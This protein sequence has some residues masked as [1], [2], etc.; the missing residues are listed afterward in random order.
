MNDKEERGK[1]REHEEKGVRDGEK[2]GARNRPKNGEKDAKHENNKKGEEKI[3]KT[4]RLSQVS[5][6]KKKKRAD[7]K[8]TKARKERGSIVKKDVRSKV[9]VETGSI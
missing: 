2:G 8:N 7:F 3:K 1:V 5:A 4:A 6:T 9:S